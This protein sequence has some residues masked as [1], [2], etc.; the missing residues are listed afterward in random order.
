MAEDV[1]NEALAT[2][3]VNKLRGGWKVRKV[4]PAMFSCIKGAFADKYGTVK[5]C[6]IKAPGFGEN[7][8]SNLLDLTILTGGQ[9]CIFYTSR[10]LYSPL[11]P[12]I[13]ISLFI[14]LPL[15][16]ILCAAHQ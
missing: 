10:F 3:I 8:K 6:A 2:L 14:R 9:V 11:A 13:P 7:R 1:E 4:F 16:L 15:P 5:I 12:L